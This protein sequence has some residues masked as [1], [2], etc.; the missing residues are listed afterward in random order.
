MAALCLA[1][2][3]C[4]RI[5]AA[6]EEICAECGSLFCSCSASILTIFPFLTVTRTWALP[7]RVSI[8]LPVAVPLPV[9]LLLEPLEVAV[10]V[11]VGA[12]AVAVWTAGAWAWKARMPAV[13]ATVAARTMGDRRMGWLRDQ[14]VK[15]SKW[16]RDSGTPAR[17][18]SAVSC[19]ARASGPHR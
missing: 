3:S 8:A 11:D 10:G 6:I 19:C 17:S 7:Y 18:S 9:P 15:D 13:P 16:M 12:E 1:S 4:S 14:D 2:A 5:G